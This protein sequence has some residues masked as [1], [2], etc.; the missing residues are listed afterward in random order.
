MD[1]FRQVIYRFLCYFSILV[2]NHNKNN[3][4]KVIETM[5]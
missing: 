2:V 3:F 1:L 4:I 5:I